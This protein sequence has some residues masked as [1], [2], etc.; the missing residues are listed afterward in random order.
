VN[1]ASYSDEEGEVSTVIAPV[2]TMRG[3][4]ATI[5]YGYYDNWLYEETYGE[6]YVIF[7]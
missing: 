7:D 2:K 1:G 5:F 4:T 3:D 6:F